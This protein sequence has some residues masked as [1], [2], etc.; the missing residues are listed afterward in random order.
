MELNYVVF[1]KSHSMYVQHEFLLPIV[2]SIAW[3]R[4]VSALCC[5]TLKKSVNADKRK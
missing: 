2:T 3:D 4:P 1:L 5:V